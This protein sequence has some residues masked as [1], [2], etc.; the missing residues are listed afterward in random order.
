MFSVPKVE[1]LSSM[2]FC[3]FLLEEPEDCHD[4][5]KRAYGNSVPCLR[6][7][8]R[9]YRKFEKGNFSLEDDERSGRPPVEDL[10]EKIRKF[11]DQDPYMSATRM[12]Y[13]LQVSLPTVTTV[14]KVKLRMRLVTAKWVPHTLTDEIKYLRVDTAKH[15]LEILEAQRSTDFLKV[16]TGDQSWFY[17]NN[18]AEFKWC[19]DD[20]P[21]P[22]KRKRTFDSRK[23]MITT[24]F[25]GNKIW[26][27]D[28]LPEDTTYDAKYHVEH[29]LPYLQ[30]KVKE[31]RP[32][33]QNHTFYLH[34]DNASPH[35]SKMAS[36]FLQTSVFKRLPHPPYSP[37]LAPLDFYF[38]GFIKGRLKGNSF[39]SKNELYKKVLGL[40]EEIK[41][42]DFLAVMK[43]WIERLKTIIENGGEYI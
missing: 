31:V 38:H 34:L 25:G 3:Y 4:M 5:L 23:V 13:Q 41:K 22:K 12:A 17:L 37:D 16:I 35:T 19:D 30:A 15:M 2:K 28:M 21:R 43:N 10:E 27:I 40:A 14:L 9:H 7:I 18:D 20:D 32:L 29:I 6:T 26:M 1:I 36:D 11:L 33:A 39:N 8:V 42:E 24:F